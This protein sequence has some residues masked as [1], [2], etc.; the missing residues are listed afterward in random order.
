MA[1]KDD[2]I[3]DYEIVST[4]LEK[5]HPEKGDIF[6]LNVNTDDP[7][8]LYSDEILESVEKLSETLHEFTGVKI[9]ILVFGDEIDLSIMNK[10][11]LLELIDRLEEMEKELEDQDNE[12]IDSE[13]ITDQYN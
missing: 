9:P 10:E 5:L 4:E 12:E 1:K 7:D 6:I 2:L 3:E 11:D 8:I 13:H